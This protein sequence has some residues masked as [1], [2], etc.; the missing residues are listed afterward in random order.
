MFVEP[1]KLNGCKA[2]E[3]AV[4]ARR[5]L[6]FPLRNRSGQPVKSANVPR[7]SYR[8]DAGSCCGVALGKKTVARNEKCNRKE[9]VRLFESTKNE[10]RLRS[11]CNP[12]LVLAVVRVIAALGSRRKSA[13]SPCGINP[14]EG[15]ELSDSIRRLCFPSLFCREP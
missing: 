4:K 3:N 11:G 12:C 2:S 14:R 6:F 5:P 10:T 7:T 9:D 15:A 8:K 13:H 1:V